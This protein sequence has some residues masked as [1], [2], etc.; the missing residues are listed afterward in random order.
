MR[1][2][3]RSGLLE[4]ATYIESPNFDTRPDDTDI[5][6]LVLHNISLPPG[7]F[8]GQGITQLFT[9][10]LDKGEHPYYEDIHHL[11]VSSHLLIRRD[12]TVI[13]YVPFHLRAWH[14]GVSCFAGRTVCNDYSIG[15]ELEGTD[16]KLFRDA[17]YWTLEKVLHAL[18]TAY[19]SLSPE[20]ITG[21]E[22]IAPMRKTDPGPCFDWHR[23]SK[24]MQ[25]EL[26]A[27]AMLKITE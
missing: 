17:Q 23:V 19:P 3:H 20:K 14:A 7:E 16:D 12:G 11:E 6:L 1:V 13:Q 4:G 26:P 18:I 2:D 21:H 25:A 9:N 27:L 8:G 22:Q 5:S 10:Q 15:I 24:A